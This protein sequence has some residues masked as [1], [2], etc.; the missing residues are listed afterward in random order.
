M[1][2]LTLT[3]FYQTETCT[4][5]TYCSFLFNKS[6]E[7]LEINSQI[8]EH[9]FGALEERAITLF[10]K[11]QLSYF[12]ALGGNNQCHLVASLIT[13]IYQHYLK[14]YLNIEKG[15][16]KPENQ[17]LQL[18]FL[19]SS[20][21]FR[22]KEETL[23][24]LFLEQSLKSLNLKAKDLSLILSAPNVLQE[25]KR[26]LSQH[27]QTYIIKTLNSFP[28]SSLEEETLL[29]ELKS[30]TS[31]DRLFSGSKTGKELYC[32]PKF[33]G[34]LVLMQRL[35][36]LPTPLIFKAK[37][38]CEHGQRLKKFGCM[39]GQDVLK[40]LEELDLKDQAPSLIVEGFSASNTNINMEAYGTLRAFCPH[41]L[42]GD[43][44]GSKASFLSHKGFIHK[45]DTHCK[46]C[47]PCQDDHCQSLQLLGKKIEELALSGFDLL[48]LVSADFTAD[49]QPEYVKRFF[50]D[51]S[52]YPIL[53]KLFKEAHQKA[54]E[55]G[56]SS[57]NPSTFLIEHL[58]ADTIEHAKSP[59]RF[60]DA[61][62][63]E[64][65][66]AMLTGENQKE[67]GL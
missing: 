10:Q 50:A 19:I 31:E 4:Q 59:K 2:S 13:N 53:S 44:P 57:N 46:A 54:G 30:L 58:Y 36:K 67:G 27:I 62:G 29:Q 52:D 41:S 51:S 16:R 49:C 42:L 14:G 28:Q 66:K 37:V 24:L 65:V 63:I 22:R 15:G 35:E 34:V 12:D 23:K 18:T 43:K 32:Y 6:A 61:P 25:S 8:A 56:L 33:S 17:F 21:F 1:T 9:V 39:R 38:L 47:T 26:L 64:H 48:N 40:P 7:E 11:G 55:Y 3:R 45:L 20:I 5:Q 60:L